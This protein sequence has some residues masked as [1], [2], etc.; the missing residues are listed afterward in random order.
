MTRPKE[1]TL[2]KKPREPKAGGRPLNLQNIMQQ[3]E[4]DNFYFKDGRKGNLLAELIDFNETPLKGGPNR[5]SSNVGISEASNFRSRPLQKATTSLTKHPLKETQQ[6][7]P[8][9]A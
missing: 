3:Q 8:K 7:G 1:G 6:P 5:F 4:N 2:K 9:L